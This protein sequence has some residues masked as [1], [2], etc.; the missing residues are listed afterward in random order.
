[1]GC[2]KIGEDKNGLIWME[3]TTTISGT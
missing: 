1:M 2:K 3:N